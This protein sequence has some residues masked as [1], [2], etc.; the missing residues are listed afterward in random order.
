[1]ARFDNAFTPNCI[2]ESSTINDGVWCDGAF[3]SSM[4]KGVP[5]KKRRVQG[6]YSE[7]LNSL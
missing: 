6:L 1:M 3:L 4:L 7:V 2:L 5:P